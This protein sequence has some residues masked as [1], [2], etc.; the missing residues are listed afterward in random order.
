M[1]TFSINETATLLL[2]L[3]ITLVNII[4]AYA[5]FIFPCKQTN[6]PQLIYE[7]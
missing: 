7:S 1:H 5:K 6:Y 3:L 2:S 4:L